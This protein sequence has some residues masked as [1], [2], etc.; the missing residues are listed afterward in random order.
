MITAILNRMLTEDAVLPQ[1]LLPFV[2]Q[3][4]ALEMGA[5]FCWQIVEPGR[6]ISTKQPADAVLSVSLAALPL[7]LADRMA[8]NRSVRIAGDEKLGMAFAQIISQLR[9]DTE[10]E[11]SHLVGD[12]MAHRLMRICPPLIVWPWQGLNAFLHTLAEYYQHESGDIVG[13]TEL[14]AFYQKVD[15]LRADTDRLEKRVARLLTT[16]VTSNDT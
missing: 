9:W 2:G 8:F 4:V 10:E 12:V 3:C 6:L 11:L 7:L 1:R 5:R 13:R 16:V 15:R 14:T